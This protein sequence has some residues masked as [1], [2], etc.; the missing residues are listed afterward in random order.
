MDPFLLT[1][2]SAKGLDAFGQFSSLRG[3]GVG[4]ELNASLSQNQTGSIIQQAEESVAQQ[5]R[6]ADKVIGSQ[7]LAYA[8]A[9]VKFEGSPTDVFLE[10]AKNIRKDIVMTRLNA[11]NS[12]NKAGFEALQHKL[13]AGRARAKSIQALGK[14]VLDIAST[15]ALDKYA[16]K[17]EG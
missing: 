16:A 12:A 8:K 9:G 5:Q 11:V 4:E 13:N 14:G 3:I 2:L 1:T 17:K 10:T 6:S 15:V 7:M